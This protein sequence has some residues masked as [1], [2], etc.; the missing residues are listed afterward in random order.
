[1]LSLLGSGF[2]GLSTT[3]TI[4]GTPCL[5]SSF[6]NANQVSCS[7]FRNDFFKL[8]NLN[9]FFLKVPSKTYSNTDTSCSLVVSVNGAT[10]SQTFTYKSSSTPMISSVNPQ[11]GKY[12]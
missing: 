9:F 8:I 1:M 3:I 11:K 4:C 6:T 5:V 7:V 2:S 12:F 10:A